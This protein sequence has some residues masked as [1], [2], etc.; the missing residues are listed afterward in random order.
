ML[1]SVEPYDD[2]NVGVVLSLWEIGGKHKVVKP[3]ANPHFYAHDDI[4]V[5]RHEVKRFLSEPAKKKGVYRVEFLTIESAKRASY[6]QDIRAFE[7][8]KRYE[9]QLVSE[10]GFAIPSGMPSV[11]SWDIETF[12]FS[13]VNP[14]PNRDTIRSISVWGLV[15]T[16][17]LCPVAPHSASVVSYDPEQADMYY[18]AVLQISDQYHAITQFDPAT[19]EFGFCWQVT[20]ELSEADAIEDALRFQRWYDA[21]IP[22]GFNDGHYDIRVLL[23]RCGAL[24]IRCAMGRNGGT[25]YVKTREYERKGKVRSV[26]TVLVNGRVHLD[27]YNEVLLDQTL[28]DL[29]GRGQ[30]E[31]SKHFGLYP[32]EGVDH[33]DLTDENVAEINLDDAR[34][35]FGLANIYLRNIYALCD[36]LSVPLNLMIERSPSH[37]PNWFYGQEYAKLGI[38]SDGFNGERFKSVFARGGKPYQGG[39]VKCYGRGLYRPVE[40]I[41]F[42]SFY[43]SIMDEYNLS[44]ETVS[45]VS[46]MP[47]TGEYKFEQYDGY[48]IIEV[49][50]VPQKK[51]KPDYEHALQ[52]RCRVETSF[53]GVTR[54][55]IRE[56]RKKRELLKREAERLRD[57]GLPFEHIESQQY[58]LK[59]IQNTLYGYSGMPFAI[60][61][62]VLMAVLITALSRYHIHKKIVEVQGQ[63]YTIIEVDTDG[64]LACPKGGEMPKSARN[65]PLEVAL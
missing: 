16:H 15:N 59:V 45:L 24:R 25:P 55:K 41:D 9:D 49:P 2:A 32:I 50:D 8:R 56:F 20:D 61:G 30:L 10:F 43:P 53:D 46:M 65:Q 54:L 5:S 4:G 18:Q 34:C 17:M 19:G 48:M 11:L 40:K 60:Y 31:V 33:G 1:L 38:V 28:F 57:A 12:T 58:A 21:D 7:N 52:F 26:D 6:L 29:K 47:Y 51:G 14:D 22:A 37:I 13:K 42:S 64:I 44:P 63:G 27:V 35:C 62:N 36:E 3:P 39:F 23:Q